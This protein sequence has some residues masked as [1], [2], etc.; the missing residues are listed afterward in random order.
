[1]KRKLAALV[2][3]CLLLTGCGT[4]QAAPEQ[5]PLQKTLFAMDTTMDLQVY[6]DDKTLLED[7]AAL[8]EELESHLSTTRVGSDIYTLNHS[9]SATLSPDTAQVM[10]RA[11]EMCRDT[12]HALDISIYPVVRAWG[13][14]TGSYQVP[15]RETLDQLLPMVDADRIDFDPATRSAAIPE[16]KE[17]DLG[18]VGK[19]YT[20]DRLSTLLRD[21]G[22]T[23]ALLNLG[24]NVQAVGTKPDGSPW[25]IAVQDPLNADGFLGVLTIADEA[26]ITSGGYER[27]FED[28]AGNVYWHIIDPATGCPAHSGLLSVTVVGPE[29]L[30]CDALSTSLFVMG[31]EKAEAYW[32]AHQDFQM[33]L[34]TEDFQL[35][36]TEGLADRFTLP[37][38][39]PYTPM[40][41]SAEAQN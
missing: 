9:G 23:S 18:A 39:S 5:T 7:A 33:I 28:E 11:L 31:A 34:L 36:L 26:A 38:N 13:F 32:R 21:R 16:G 3:A 10:G 41:L 22:V 30:R 8:V 29:G 2:C 12:D 40:V 25:R 20:G 6:S 4:S 24:G 27:Y 19:G 15:S 17:V 14:T 1:M 37:E 35:L